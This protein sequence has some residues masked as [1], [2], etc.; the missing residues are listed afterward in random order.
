MKTFNVSRPSQL[1]RR[2]HARMQGLSLV[3]V[4]VALTIGLILTLGMVGL[5]G[6]NAQNL[7]I[8]E[9]ISESQENARMAFELIARDVR[10]AGDTSCGPLGSNSVKKLDPNDDDPAW[11]QEWWPLRGFAEDEATDAVS[12]GST[13]AEATRVSETQALQVHDTADVALIRQLNAPSNIVLQENSAGFKTGDTILLCDMDSAS[14]HTVDAVAGTTL[15]VSPDISLTD[16]DN[17][18]F[19]V[20]RHAATTWY[21]GNNGRADEGGR[22]LY[23]A[24]LA[25]NGSVIREEILPGVVD[26]Q[27]RYHRKGTDSLTLV[28]AATLTTGSTTQS[29][30]NW[31]QINAIELTL[32]TEST[33]KNVAV[34]DESAAANDLVS[35][36]DR[37][38]R[39]SIT[40]YIAL[41][42]AH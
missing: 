35:Q 12:F 1:S 20:A 10:Q 28:D 31:A 37:R 21:I 4:M 32:I 14:M 23:R 38:L 6:G 41:R 5:M 3:E 26:M 24:R 29:K 27:L 22:S 11:W 13:G 33:H 40:Y 25:N 17:P 18:Q 39:R 19:Q 16:S 34:V 30:N 36:E 15:T 2:T 8:T 7:R 42:N 9:S